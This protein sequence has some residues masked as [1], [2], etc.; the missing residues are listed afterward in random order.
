LQNDNRVSRGKDRQRITRRRAI[1]NVAADRAARLDLHA[2]HEP[3][4]LD[5]HREPL[6]HDRRANE[7]RIRSQCTKHER[8]T[9]RTDRPQLAQIPDVHV[10]LRRR[11]PELELNIHIRTAC[12]RH[13]VIGPLQLEGFFQRARPY[14]LERCD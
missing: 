4:R 2:T 9:V 6:M 14:D 3:R 7:V 8:I 5:E 13:E 11:L 10:A 12:K 1:R